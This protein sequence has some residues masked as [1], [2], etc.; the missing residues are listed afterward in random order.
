MSG[1][2]GSGGKYMMDLAYDFKANFA[3]VPGFVSVTPKMKCLVVTL[4]RG[5]SKTWFPAEFMGV[6]VYYTFEEPV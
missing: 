1:E 4:E 3:S 2:I 5:V 6:P